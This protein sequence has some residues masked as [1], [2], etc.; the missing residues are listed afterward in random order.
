MIEEVE[1]ALFL[2]LNGFHT[3]ILDTIML[4]ITNKYTWIPLYLVMLVMLTFQYKRQ[5]WLPLLLII[6]SILL[7]DQWASGLMK[8]LVARLRP[9]HEPTLTPYIHRI[10]GCGSQYGFMSSHAANSFAIAVLVPMLN[11]N[12]R[13]NRWLKPILFFWAMAVA[14]SRVYIGVHYVGDIVAGGLSGILIA[15]SVHW[16]G[17]KYLK[18]HFNKVITLQ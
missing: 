5:V 7:A 2:W 18:S 13:W 11:L 8:P 15:L 1:R 17:K 12:L 16:L 10:I 3:P 4:I 14:Y 6:L 9:C